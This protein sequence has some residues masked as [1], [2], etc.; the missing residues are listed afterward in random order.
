MT[1]RPSVCGTAAQ[2]TGSRSQSPELP[3]GGLGP[4]QDKDCQVRGQLWCT[5]LSTS[6]RDQERSQES[7][8]FLQLPLLSESAKNLVGVI[9]AAVLIDPPN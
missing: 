1:K 5:P 3:Q 2:C 8:P 7:L 4:G 9:P 6:Q